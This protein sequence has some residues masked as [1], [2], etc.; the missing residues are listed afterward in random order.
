VAV[1]VVLVRHGETAWSREGRHTGRTDI[2][3]EPAGRW[4]AELIG[5]RL[6]HLPFSMVL[7]SPLKRARETCELAGFADQAVPDPDLMEWDY[8]DYEGRRTEDIREERPDWELFRDGCPRGESFDDVAARVRR[9]IARVEGAPGDV[10]LFAH[11]HLLRT[12]AACWVEM[13]PPLG[14]VLSLAPGAI[15]ILG[16]ERETHVILLWNDGSHLEAT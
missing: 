1:G 16:H 8:G 2:P 12:L 11:G 13:G 15:S 5:A 10:A 4:H 6:R 7:T 9:V 14:T 3:L